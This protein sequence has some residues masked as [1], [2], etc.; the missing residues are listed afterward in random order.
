MKFKNKCIVKVNAPEVGI[1]E[2]W[3]A[4]LFLWSHPLRITDLS[5]VIFLVR[6][7]GKVV[8]YIRGNTK[9]ILKNKCGSQPLSWPPK[10]PASWC[11]HPCVVLPILNWADLSNQ[12]AF[13]E[14]IIANSKARS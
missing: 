8:Y 2:Y 6:I 3:T 7:N 10:I 1:L 13:S 14:I 5:Q 12:W 11:P 4:S 9:Y